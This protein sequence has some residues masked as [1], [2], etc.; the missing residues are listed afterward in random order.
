MAAANTSKA[1][2]YA[3]VT[4]YLDKIYENSPQFGSAGLT[5]TFHDGEITRVDVSETVQRRIAPRS[6]GQP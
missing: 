2:F 1:A 4:H 6:G 3:V 5:L